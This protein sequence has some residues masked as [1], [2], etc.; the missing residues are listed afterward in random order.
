[1]P[2]RKNR[3]ISPGACIPTPCGKSSDCGSA[4]SW[5][6]HSVANAACGICATVSRPILSC[7]GTGPVRIP[8][9][10]CPC[11]PA[12]WAM[13]TSPTRSGIWRALPTRARA[14]RRT[15]LG[16]LEGSITIT[17]RDPD[18]AVAKAHDVQNTTPPNLGREAA[19]LGCHP[20]CRTQLVAHRRPAIL[21]GP[22]GQ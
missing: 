11:C 3:K 5:P 22:G 17:E 12:T 15:Q 6:R 20:C 16:R 21:V 4:F 14:I 10:D 9:N 2:S 1:M 18:S 8:K 13:F 7:N 19:P